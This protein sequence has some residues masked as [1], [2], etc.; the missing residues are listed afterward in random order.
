MILR[1]ETI[2]NH[3]GRY[4]ANLLG[5]KSSGHPRACAAR[6]RE[7]RTA[8]M[9]R[10][11]GAVSLLLARANGIT[12]DGSHKHSSDDIDEDDFKW[13]KLPGRC[14]FL[15]HEECPYEKAPRELCTK[16]SASTCDECNVWSEPDNFCHTSP[17]A[18][19]TCSMELYCPAPPPLVAGNK[20]CT[21]ASRVGQG[22][23]DE[24]MTGVCASHT[25]ADCQDACR[26]NNNCDVFV[27][28]QEEGLGSCVL[29]SD[30][31]ESVETPG[32][33]TRAYVI[34]PAAPP[35]SSI[36]SSVNKKYSLVA[37]PPPPSPPKSPPKPLAAGKESMELGR[38]HKTKTVTCDY[39]EGVEYMVDVSTGYTDRTASSKDECCRLCGEREGCK[40]FVFEPST[41]TCVLLPDTVIEDVK[42]RPNLFVVSGSVRISAVK[43]V[44][45]A[46]SCKY[47][48]GS[49]FAGSV[50]GAGMPI[51]G[52]EMKSMADCCESCGRAVQCTKFTFDEGANMCTLHTSTAEM[53]M[54]S[55]RVS[56]TIEGKG[57]S[58][59]SDT[60]NGYGL[61]YPPPPSMPAFS[62][63]HASPPPPPI[64]ANDGVG[65]QDVIAY[66]SVAVITLLMVMFLCVAF[67]FFSPQLRA[68]RNRFTQRGAKYDL[69]KGETDPMVLPEGGAKR[70]KK[71]GGK[72]GHAKVIVQTTGLTQSKDMD[73]SCDSSEALVKKIFE[74]FSH[75]VK[76]LRPAHTVLLCKALD[77]EDEEDEESNNAEQWLL[78]D[79]ESDFA[80]V[81]AQCKAFKLLEQKR[82]AARSK[83]RLAFPAGESPLRLTAQPERRSK[84]AGEEAS[85][86]GKKG[87]KDEKKRGT[88][89]GKAGAGESDD[90]SDANSKREPTKPPAN[91]S[92]DKPSLWETGEE[93]KPVRAELHEP[94]A[95]AA[96]EQSRGVPHPIPASGWHN[97]D[98]DGPDFS[99]EMRARARVP[100]FV[101]DD[102]MI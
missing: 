94:A 54:V 15:I 44:T 10:A 80:Q 29:C 34:T 100:T 96:V 2:N 11:A 69:A 1:S 50:L 42:H 76:G 5:R 16:T 41:G 89:K 90:D 51:P 38:Q 58:F 23:F 45:D 39:E 47:K 59:A 14:C 6:R 73:V 63:L 30:L 27:F 25:M 74:E 53:Y 35:P 65:A 43:K 91:K 28:Y 68:I 4:K 83:Y 36:G 88:R 60:S 12:V 79:E 85:S 62:K 84:K 18:C 46:A 70:K 20:V 9:R 40:D 97:D 48:E 77:V 3:L 37:E 81:L 71:R 56:G 101:P 66:I 32:A 93:K 17:E 92:A 102:D 19:D 95:A 22:C 57:V 7:E 26:K 72:A 98:G 82:A 24:L 52:G 61:A 31:L 87:K 67:F 86:G 13:E 75:V 78:V 21:G 99:K 64:E 33:A 8:L 49:A 55:G